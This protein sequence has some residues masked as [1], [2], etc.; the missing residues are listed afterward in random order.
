MADK[1]QFDLVS[2]ERLLMSEHA[3]MVVVPG[4]E[5]DF[6]VLIGHAP[7]ISAV[8][9]GII[10][11]HDGNAAPRRIFVAGGFA[12]VTPE[13]L[14]VL[15]EEAMPIDRLDRGEIETSLRTLQADLA[16]AQTDSERTRFAA[17]ITVAE[18]KLEALA[19]A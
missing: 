4:A 14:T 13:R 2:P 15:A 18:A 12:E 16:E 6:G 9:P 19:R 11:V 7:F 3:E 10:E 1:V 17:A 5:G 8:R